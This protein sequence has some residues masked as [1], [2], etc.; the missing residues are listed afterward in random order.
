M[1]MSVVMATWQ[2]RRYLPGQLASLRGQTR[3]P[4]EVVIVDDASDDGTVEIVKDFAATAEFEVVLLRQEERRGS[5]AAFERGIS[6]A[7]GD[8]IALAD[9]DDLWFPHKLSRIRSVFAHSPQITFVF[10]D[11]TLIDGDDRPLDGTLWSNRKFTPK[12]QRAVRDDAFGQMAQRYLVTG[13]T[14]AF[15]S[16]LV[17]VA[18]PVPEEAIRATPPIVH[19]RWLSLVLTALGPVE[20]LDEPLLA[21]RIHADQQIGLTATSARLGPLQS[22]ARKVFAPRDYTFEQRDQQI[23]LIEEVQRRAEAQRTTTPAM[24]HTIDSVLGYLQFRRDQPEQRIRRL[25]PI[26]R[27]TLMGTYHRRSRG[28][29]SAAV[30]LFRP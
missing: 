21:Y 14:M 3:P 22:A 9:Q 8:V 7:S 15:R 24:L 13:C 16:D 20:V 11:A 26:L 12:L 19:D 5:T 30:D 1:R 6:T 17:P 27:Q 18:L 10:T 28:V 25:G 23:K 4:D 29:A 2:G